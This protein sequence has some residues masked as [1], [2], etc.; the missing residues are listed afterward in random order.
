MRVEETSCIHLVKPS[1]SKQGHHWQTWTIFRQFLSIS[2]YGDHRLSVQP[3]PMFRGPH[4]KKKTKKNVCDQREHPMFQFVFIDSCPG[5][6]W[7]ESGSVS[8]TLSLQ[9]FIYI[10]KIHHHQPPKPSIF[11]NPLCGKLYKIAISLHRLLIK[12]PKCRKR[13]ECWVGRGRRRDLCQDSPCSC[14]FEEDRRKQAAP[15]TRKETVLTSLASGIWNWSE[16]LSLP[17]DIQGTFV[18][19]EKNY[20]RWFIARFF[21]AIIKISWL[22]WLVLQP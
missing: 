22:Y 6:H 10:N 16:N 14:T 7:E 19:V 2:K 3:V 8:F 1:F 13:K 21:Y 4:S 11:Q 15:S 9:L 12:D 17:L 5:H 18:S 20:F